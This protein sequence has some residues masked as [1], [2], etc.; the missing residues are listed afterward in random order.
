MFGKSKINLYTDEIDNLR[1]KCDVYINFPA[2]KVISVERL[3]IGY[4]TEKTV[5]GHLI[6]EE[7]SVD[8]WYIFCSRAQHNGLVKLYSSKLPKLE[9]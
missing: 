9:I 4:E 1:A 5:I 2:D 6:S 8:E 7:N 3:N